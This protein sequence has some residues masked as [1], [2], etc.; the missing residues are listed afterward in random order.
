MVA[1]LHLEG[2]TRAWNIGEDARQCSDFG[3]PELVIVAVHDPGRAMLNRG[4]PRHTRY[5]AP[6]AVGVLRLENAVGQPGVDIALNDLGGRVGRPIIGDDEVIYA[7]SQ[8][9]LDIFPQQTRC[10]ANE[11]GHYDL[12]VAALE[13][14]AAWSSGRS[15]GP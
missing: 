3:R 5:P 10:V 1:T 14:R 2:K 13:L 11:Q 8:V 9:M 6:L 7:L 12:H 4:A 15:R